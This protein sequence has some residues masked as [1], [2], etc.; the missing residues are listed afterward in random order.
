MAGADE[1]VQANRRWWD[2]AADDY[3]SEHGE[4]LGGPDAARF[5]WGPEGLDEADAQLLGPVA[6]L[7]GRRVLEVGC[8]AAQCARWLAS[9][10]RVAPWPLT[11]PCAS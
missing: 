4:F 1:T 7:A 10:G 5:I 2:A 3:Q 6:D 9:P 8:G 11:C